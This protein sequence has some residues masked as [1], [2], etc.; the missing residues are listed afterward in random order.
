VG[1]GVNHARCLTPFM[2]EVL[3]ALETPS[4]WATM[5]PADVNQECTCGFYAYTDPKGREFESPHRFNGIIEGFGNC[6]IGPLGFRCSKM[7]I[8][9][10]VQPHLRGDDDPMRD[11]WGDKGPKIL[12]S[13]GRLVA[14]NYGIP[15]FDTYEQAYREFPLTRYESV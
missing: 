1:A 12:P 2:S 8:L 4:L 13:V 5:T 10:L 6:V 14:R 7:R 11:L 15:L 9:A 3:F